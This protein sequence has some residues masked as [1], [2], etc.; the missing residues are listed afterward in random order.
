MLGGML[1]YFST[2]NRNRFSHS[3]NLANAQSL[4]GLGLI[5]A[6][7]VAFA[8]DAKHSAWSALVPDLGS[9]LVIAAGTTGTVNRR[10]LGNPAMVLLGRISYPLYL[11]HWPLLSFVTIVESGV[12]TVP[13]R[14]SL[15]ALSVLLAGLTYRFVEL[16]V[17]SIASLRGAMPL[18]IVYLAL[19]ALGAAVYAGHGFPQRTQATNSL[20]DAFEWKSKGLFERDDCGRSLPTR[21]LTDGKPAHVA[22]I[23]DSLSTNTFFVLQEVYRSRD[24]GVLRLG[25]ALCLPFYDVEH[26]QRGV[27][28]NCREKMNRS[29]D[30]VLKDDR[31]RTVVFSLRSSLFLASTQG[32]RL[33]SYRD[34][35]P[36]AN[37]DVFRAALER[38]I[39]RF[40]AAGKD[41]VYVLE[42]P[43]LDFDPKTCV[44]IRPLRFHRF[45]AP[46]CGVDREKVEARD[47]SYRAL[48]LATLARYP[49]TTYWDAKKALCDDRTCWAFKDGLMLY[50][51]RDHLSLVGSEYLAR[52]FATE[53]PQPPQ[54]P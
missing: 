17:R 36:S 53:T 25:K 48:V 40:T 8:G 5:L 2:T 29:L 27:S 3:Q 7:A 44:D 42:W 54:R 31:I 14:L 13:W 18:L 11:W 20:L 26:F 24:E 50:R 21:C 39:E 37:P 43:Q 52:S 23:G 30:H 19:G 33:V 46:T 47:S 6:S 45:R 49:R 12:P 22:V 16:P 51:D 15:L 28:A 34:E 1:A 41:V 38:T 10:L 35:A 9:L 32:N 4:L